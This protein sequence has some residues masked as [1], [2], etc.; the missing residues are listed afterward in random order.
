VDRRNELYKLPTFKQP[1]DTYQTQVSSS[2]GGF[3]RDQNVL[4]VPVLTTAERETWLHQGPGN[5][6]MR[7]RRGEERYMVIS[8]NGVIRE[9]NQDTN[10]LQ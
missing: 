2:D 3:L 10:H 8:N 4:S 7:G 6:Y 9:S 5:Y 1:T